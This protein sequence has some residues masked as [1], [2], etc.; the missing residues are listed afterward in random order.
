MTDDGG[1][2]RNVEIKARLHDISKAHELAAELSGGTGT[3]LHQQDTFFLTQRGR[4]KLRS[5]KQVS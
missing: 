1:A 4:M 2:S 3:V 5:I